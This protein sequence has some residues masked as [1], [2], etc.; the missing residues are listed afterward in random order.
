LPALAAR[1]A[2][3]LNGLKLVATL[4]LK[5]VPVLTGVTP[6][7]IAGTPEGGVTGVCV[8]DA[9]GKEHAFD[10]DAVGLGYHLRPETQLADLARCQFRFDD[11]SRQWLPRIDA[12]ETLVCRCEAVTAG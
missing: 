1:P 9:K 4:R 7:L 6:L 8:R 10:C 2:V 12:D 3:L 11:E 5:R